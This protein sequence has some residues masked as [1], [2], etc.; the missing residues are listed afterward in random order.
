MSGASSANRRYMPGYLSESCLAVEPISAASL[1][2]SKSASSNPDLTTLTI[3]TILC[4]VAPR[5]ATVI[6][7]VLTRTGIRSQR[8]F[9]ATSGLRLVRCLVKRF[10]SRE[11]PPPAYIKMVHIL[12]VVTLI[13]SDILLLSEPSKGFSII[14]QQVLLLYRMTLWEW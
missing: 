14:R 10:V 3:L 11:S 13:K 12:L 8:I 1:S 6:C 9:R 2:K 5:T 4:A 7:T